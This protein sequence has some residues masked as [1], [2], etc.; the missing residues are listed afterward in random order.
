MTERIAHVWRVRPGMA[1]EYLR[2][3]RSI[4]PELAALLRAAGIRSYTIYLWGDLVFSHMEVDDYARLIDRLARDPVA[5]RWEEEFVGI[6][7][8]PHA[9]PKTGWPERAIEVWDL[10]QDTPTETERC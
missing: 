1:D 4:G 8:Y 3:H 5:G 9:D 7:E 2:R 6:L 10:D